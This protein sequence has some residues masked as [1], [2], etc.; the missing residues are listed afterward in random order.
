MKRLKTN[1]KMKNKREKNQRFFQYNF[2]PKSRRELKLTIFPKNRKAILMPETLKIII[3]V[4][5]IGLL[6]YLSV[7]LYGVFTQKSKV[8]QAKAIL[9]QIFAEIEGLEDG[10]KGD[11]L[12]TSPKEWYFVVY[13]EGEN[14]P[15]QCKGENCLC[16]CPSSKDL[17]GL[18][19][20]FG[21]V[22]SLFYKEEEG[23]N[24]CEKEG[25]CKNIEEEIEIREAYFYDRDNPEKKDTNVAFVNWISFYDIPKTLFFKKQA[26]TLYIS[27]IE[28]DSKIIVDF[29]NKEVEFENQGIIISDLILRELTND[30]SLELETDVWEGSIIVDKEVEEFLKSESEDYLSELIEKEEIKGGKMFFTTVK[31]IWFKNAI[32]VSEGDTKNCYILEEKQIC[33]NIVDEYND[34]RWYLRMYIC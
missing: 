16:I 17:E 18:K 29:L 21:V 14:M 30:C 22:D 26:E 24:K 25:V 27:D 10:E 33:P 32:M 31:S 34:R 8:E 13:E 11:Y 19:E 6:V 23:I 20:D 28:I 15:I 1:F 3:A 7:S 4:I 5:C 12:V 9:D 2:F